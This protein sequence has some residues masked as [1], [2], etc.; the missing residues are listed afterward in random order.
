VGRRLPGVAHRVLGDVHEAP[1]RAL[2]HPHRG[3][4]PPLPP[5]RG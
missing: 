4:R 5:P 2:R 3:D 1:R